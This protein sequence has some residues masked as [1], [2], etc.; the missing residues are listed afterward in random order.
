MMRFLLICCALSIPLAGAE[1]KSF[2]HGLSEVEIKESGLDKLTAAERARLDELVAAK[3]RAAA[4][5]VAVSV[6]AATAPVAP[7]A[8]AAPAKPAILNGKIAGTM[9]GWSEGTV[10]VLE[11]GQRWTVLDK[12]TYR[13]APVRRAPKVELFPLSNGDYVMTIQSVP[14][15]AIVRRV[16]E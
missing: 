8:P 7:V 4:E 12:G 14:R 3:T 1:E 15:R 2:S 16:V 10:L 11:D 6:P 5:V 13:A 9:S